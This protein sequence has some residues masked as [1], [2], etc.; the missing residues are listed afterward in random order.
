MTA[1]NKVEPEEIMVHQNGKPI[2]PVILTDSFYSLPKS[3]AQLNLSGRK[4]CIVTDSRVAKLY[5]E[6]IKNIFDSISEKI[7][8]FVFP[9]GEPYK[10]L[11]T[12]KSLYEYLICHSFDRNDI[13]VALGGGVTGD[14]TGFTAATY[15]RGIDFIQVPTTLLS[16][17]D[18][19]IGGKT[20]VDFD[21]YKNMVGAFY[22][23]RLVYIN[24][25]VLKSLPEEQFASG[26]G[27]VIK[28]GCIRSGEYY[29]W[30]EA[31]KESIRQ[32][33]TD[34]MAAMVKGS[35]LIKRA[36][37]E[38]D[39]TEK[40]IRALLNFGHT[41]GHAIEKEKGF[42]LSHGACV[43]VGCVAAAYLSERRGMLKPEE[44]K[45]LEELLA[46]F[47]IPVSLQDI[48]VSNVLDAVKH[49][50]KMDSGVIRFILLRALGDACIDKTV[51][52]EE[53][54]SAMDYLTKPRGE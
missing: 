46:Y 11:D 16:Q 1:E 12:V 23:P 7:V 17:V 43:G 18:S 4:V 47:R 52:A 20:G 40:G 24:V 50:K 22:M 35:C 13:L 21:A 33:K 29:H 25:S 44:F 28:H 9:A 5:L 51:S 34:F 8:Y 32:R 2:Y 42:T 15:L 54:E 19:S 26:M 3:A 36:V 38:E 10:N 53:M 31:N 27:E 30:L 6:E 48:N 14:L 49:D 41:L 45:N 39:P 37:V